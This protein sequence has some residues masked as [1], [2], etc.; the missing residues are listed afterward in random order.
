MPVH[1]VADNRDVALSPVA[2]THGQGRV[3]VHRRA[4]V[5]NERGHRLGLKTCD[6]QDDVHKVASRVVQLSS[7]GQR[8]ILS[9]C[10][11][12]AVLP[13]LALQGIDERD[14]SHLARSDA[15]ADVAELCLVVALIGEQ[16][17]LPRGVTLC[18]HLLCILDG[19]D[20]GLLAEDMHAGIQRR[21]YLL[22]VKGVGSADDDG[23]HGN[24]R[25]HL[26]VIG[27]RRR[28]SQWRMLSAGGFDH[29]GIRVRDGRDS[30]TG[31]GQHL[32]HVVARVAATSDEADAQ[33]IGG[34]HG[35][36]SMC[37]NVMLAR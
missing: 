5:V 22:F 1:G 2:E 24:A 30:D 20:E 37:W 7:T 27:K 21:E 14:R 4:A 29:G 10:A 36:F 9:P 12:G 6:P 28:V 17:Y 31:N 8:R 32:A 16:A 26:T 25:Q 35:A 15:G 33:R 34:G 19:A 3:D 18:D 23:I 11:S 13:V